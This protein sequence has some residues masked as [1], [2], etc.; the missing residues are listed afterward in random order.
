MKIGDGRPTN[1]AIQETAHSL[2]RYA[3]IC[4]ENGLA[5][6]V[7][8]EILTDGS[9]SLCCCAK[10]TERVIAACVEALHLHNVFLEGCMLKPNMVTPGAT[11][12]DKEKI[13]S[14]D[15]A[16]MTVRTLARTLPAAMPGVVFLSGGQ[17]EEDAT[18]QLNEM[19]KITEYPKPW[20]LTFSYGR[21]LQ[22]SCLKAW[23]GKVENVKAAQDALMARVMANGQ[24]ST[25]TYQG[26][27]AGSQESTYVAN[28]SY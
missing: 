3:A 12:P 5:P 1:L 14:R 23:C 13:T 17:S 18:L 4:Q 19:N 15:M 7:E 8:P 24:A 22:A 25:G 10:V 2:A 9:H 27:A 28:Y 21:A 6:I 16:Y 20:A 26:G 11:C